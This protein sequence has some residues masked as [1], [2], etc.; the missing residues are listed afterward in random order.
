MAGRGTTYIVSL[1]K[2]YITNKTNVTRLWEVVERELGSQEDL[3]IAYCL[4]QEENRNRDYH[5]T[6]ARKQKVKSLCQET[7]RNRILVRKK[8]DED[9]DE[10][11]IAIFQDL[12]GGRD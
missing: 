5:V 4:T 7:Y 11:F 6:L 12:I 10:D 2:R 1:N 8:D 9:L 3:E